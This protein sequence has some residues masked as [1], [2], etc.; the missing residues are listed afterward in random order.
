MIATQFNYDLKNDKIKLYWE[1]FKDMDPKKFISTV[2]QIMDTFVPT[3][4]APFPLFVHFLGGVGTLPGNPQGKDAVRRVRYAVGKFG[5]YDSVNFGDSKLHQ[6][7]KYYGG[8]SIICN[9]I[10]TDWTKLEREFIK[11]Y[12]SIS[13]DPKFTHL[14]GIHEHNNNGKYN[15]EPPKLVYQM[16]KEKPLEILGG[17]DHN[18]T[19]MIGDENA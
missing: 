11:T 13:P 12:E 2:Q 14:P 17:Y 15:V 18:S 5:R 19:L 6:T 8:W 9:W 10:D 4:S 16:M 7:I 3:S 1:R